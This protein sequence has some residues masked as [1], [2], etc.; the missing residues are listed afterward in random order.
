MTALKQL[1]DQEGSAVKE[2]HVESVQSAYDSWWQEEKES[3]ERSYAECT[4]A[5]TWKMVVHH[6]SRG[7][8][9]KLLSSTLLRCSNDLLGYPVSKPAG[10]RFVAL[11]TK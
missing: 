9:R 10:T 5:E 8:F 4:D 11:V 1:P 7:R 3:L 2:S 6:L